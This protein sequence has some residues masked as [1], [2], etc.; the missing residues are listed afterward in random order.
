M[1]KDFAIWWTF[2]MVGFF[3]GL[4][5]MLI[6]DTNAREKQAIERGYMEYDKTTGKLDWIK[7]ELEK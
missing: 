3:G 2:F 1:S 5:V 6:C 7:K 4:T